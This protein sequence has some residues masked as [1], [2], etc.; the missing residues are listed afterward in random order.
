MFAAAPLA[1]LIFLAVLALLP[2]TGTTIAVSVGLRR[3]ELLP[4]IARIGVVILIVMT[5]L[6]S[7]SGWLV[8]RSG[9]W[10]HQ[11]LTGIT[12]TTLVITTPFTIGAI[13]NATKRL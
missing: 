5:V 7:V 2:A 13:F 9:L 12:A 8:W 1:L 3:P 4:R 10:S 11:N 6:I